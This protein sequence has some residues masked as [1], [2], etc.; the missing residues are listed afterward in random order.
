MD[1]LPIYFG[2]ML[3]LVVIVQGDGPKVRVGCQVFQSR[4]I[5]RAIVERE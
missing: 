1:G 3:G 2:P 4:L 5:G